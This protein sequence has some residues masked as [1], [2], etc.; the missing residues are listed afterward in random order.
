MDE[1]ERNLARKA[2]LASTKAEVQKKVREQLRVLRARIRTVAKHAPVHHGHAHG[3]LRP[4]S[5]WAT[6]CKHTHRMF[7]AVPSGECS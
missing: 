4:L 6:Q 7:P 3:C 1:V 5:W 2:A